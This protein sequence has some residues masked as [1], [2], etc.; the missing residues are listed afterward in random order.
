M[1]FLIKHHLLKDKQKDLTPIK[2]TASLVFFL[3]RSCQHKIRKIRI[4]I[5]SLP[6]LKLCI[7]QDYKQFKSTYLV[8]F[9]SPRKIIET[10]HFIFLSNTTLQEESNQI[11]FTK[12]GHSKLEI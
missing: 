1:N 7:L 3:V 11:W 6:Y 12:I 2:F 4:T 8:P 9:N 5:L 10:V